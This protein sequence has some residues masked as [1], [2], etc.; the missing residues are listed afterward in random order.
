MRDIIGQNVAWYEKY[1]PNEIED[2]VFEDEVTA[3]KIKG[4]VENKCIIGNIISYGDGGTGKS[5]I[6]RVLYKSIIKHKEDIFKLK[7][8]V[9]SIEEL[10]SWILDVSQGGTQ[11]IVVCEEFDRL[12]KEAQSELKDGLMEHYMPQVAFLVTT[13][14]IHSI[15]PALLQRF[16]EKLNFTK[17][18]VDGVYWRMKHILDSE[19][20][21][22]DD[23]DV[24]ALVN[25]YSTKGIRDLISSLQ[26]G[27]IQG[28]FSTTNLKGFIGTTGI[29]EQFINYIKYFFQLMDTYEL[30]HIY[31]T[32]LN[33]TADQT[34]SG[35]YEPML[36]KMKEDPSIN[37]EYIFKKLLESTDILLP[38]K[39]VIEEYYQDL[40]VKPLQHIHLQSCIFHC[41]ATIYT[42]KGG[43]KR[44]IH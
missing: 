37:Y 19:K 32:C 30:E 14:N 43:E 40:K 11:R 34:I 4:F 6:N 18:N 29:E 27:T 41:F 7:K 36:L 5:T 42:I 9:A 3:A 33:P 38:L 21:E 13:N 8:G 24:Y 16:N 15:D 31:N 20:V 12:S 10:R 2:V 35:F 44:M 28:K 23:N 22:Y 39:K 25:S 26:S 1:R 17:F